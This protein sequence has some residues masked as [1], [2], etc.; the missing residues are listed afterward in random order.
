MSFYLTDFASIGGCDSRALME[1]KFYAVEDHCEARTLSEFRVMEEH[2][3]SL[4]DCCRSNFPQSISDCCEAG[5]DDCVLS[6][7]TKFIPVST[8]SKKNSSFSLHIYLNA[9]SIPF[10]EEM[11]RPNMLHQG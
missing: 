2:F 10:C 4:D 5:D 8:V 1:L 3:D 9:S 11:A 7:D 6:G